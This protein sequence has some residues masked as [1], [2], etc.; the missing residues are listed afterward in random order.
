MLTDYTVGKSVIYQ[1]NRFASPSDFLPDT[2]STIHI[3][4]GTYRV[5]TDSIVLNTIDSIRIYYLTIN[6]VGTE[7]YR[8][9]L[10]IIWSRHVDTLYN[11]VI[12]EYLNSDYNAAG[13]RIKGWIFPDT[14]YQSP[15]CPYDSTIFY[16]YDYFYRFYHFP[17]TDTFDVRGDTLILTNVNTDC[18]DAGF[19]STF[20][21]TQS[22][23]LLMRGSYVFNFFDWSFAD[24]FTKGEVSAANLSATL[25]ERIVLYNNYPNPFN[26]TTTIS[27]AVASRQLV[28]LKV[29]DVLGKE[30]ATLV[31]EEKP[32]G[33][34]EIEFSATSLP[35][36]IY[37]YRLQA[38]SF[39][40]T[41]KMVLMK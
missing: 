23:G 32:A 29:Y 11:D 2:A 39:V 5:Y 25:P 37:F 22:D 1:F 41:K 9:L 15:R 14:V 31:N 3:F 30:I 24:T 8:N 10:R 16:P 27:Y 21:I 34:Y 36:G 33:G 40:E 19:T 26:P 18:F 17:S 7:V 6:K 13:N 4:N 28:T 20:R 35:S 38:G 12:E